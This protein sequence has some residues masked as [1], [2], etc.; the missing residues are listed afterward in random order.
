MK[1][2]APE[3]DSGFPRAYP[4][5]LQ[6]QTR[7]TFTLRPCSLGPRPVTVKFLSASSLPRNDMRPLRFGFRKS[8]N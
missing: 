3:L 1:P 2:K 4:T 5:K 8:R 6:D 7:L